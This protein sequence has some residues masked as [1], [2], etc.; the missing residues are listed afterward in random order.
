MSGRWLLHVLEKADWKRETGMDK[1]KS[2]FKKKKIKKLIFCL[3]DVPRLTV[4]HSLTHWT[5]TPWTTAK[6][7]KEHEF[8][9]SIQIL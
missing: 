8:I 9:T 3:P 1:Q 7:S 6:T 2:G 4:C 5:V